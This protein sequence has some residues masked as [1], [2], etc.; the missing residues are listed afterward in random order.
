[1]FAKYESRD[2]LRRA[3]LSYLRDRARISPGFWCD[4]RL[5]LA[6]VWKPDTKGK[7]PISSP[8]HRFSSVYE[9]FHASSTQARPRFP[10]LCPHGDDEV[11]SNK[12]HSLRKPVNARFDSASITMLKKDWRG[13]RSPFC[14]S[15]QRT[16]SN[17]Q[18]PACIEAH[19]VA[20]VIR[21]HET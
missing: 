14:E 18:L 15:P 16:D 17:I 12:F 2:Q 9:G 10:C 21:S 11:S 8:D 6:T 4:D 19:I 1:M 20:Q 5:A 7:R 13:R 3:A